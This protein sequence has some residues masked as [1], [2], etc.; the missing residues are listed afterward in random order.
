MKDKPL[1]VGQHYPAIDGLRGMAVLLVIWFH[2]AYFVTIG[3]DE[4]LSGL[5]YG[6]Y[7]LTM[8]GETGVDLFFVLSRFFDNRY[9]N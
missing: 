9:F 6:Y 3:M 7:L 5:T 8:L 2:S 1:I 4:Q